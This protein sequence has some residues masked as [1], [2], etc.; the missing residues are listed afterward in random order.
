MLAQTSPVLCAQCMFNIACMPWGPQARNLS[1]IRQPIISQSHQYRQAYWDR[2]EPERSLFCTDLKAQLLVKSSGHGHVRIGTSPERHI[3]YNDH[4]DHTTSSIQGASRNSQVAAGNAAGLQS[5]GSRPANM[6]A[7]VTFNIYSD[8]P[9][10]EPSRQTATHTPPGR[11]VLSSA[12]GAGGRQNA[13]LAG[14]GAVADHERRMRT[15]AGGTSPAFRSPSQRVSAQSSSS[16][17]RRSQGGEHASGSSTSN[18]EG[19][20]RG[21]LRDDA[22]GEG[23]ASGN[24]AKQPQ[25]V[26]L[27][28]DGNVLPG[29][30]L[31]A[32]GNV[33]PGQERQ[34]LRGTSGG[35]SRSGARDVFD[36]QVQPHGSIKPHGSMRTMDEGPD[37]G[38]DG[39]SLSGDERQAHAPRVNP[40]GMQFVQRA[41]QPE[42][43]RS[44][45]VHKNAT[46]I[47]D[48]PATTL[49]RACLCPGKCPLLFSCLVCGYKVSL[50]RLAAEPC[51]ALAC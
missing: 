47:F 41:R 33:L 7:N 1:V 28:A 38:S 3:S 11:T 48:D 16:G 42:Q 10:G 6:A 43:L 35:R 17:E 39:G 51:Q 34:G 18:V 22:T 44:H 2:A 50:L 5:E 45:E 4:H 8:S 13:P 30:Q 15:S 36:P 14:G 23:S 9:D 25:G 26:Q 49:V 24:Q 27:D 19:G 37:K 21:S 29:L 32:D 31:D 12:L 46:L 20:E 40:A